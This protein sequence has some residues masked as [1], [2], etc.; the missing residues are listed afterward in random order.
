VC[1]LHKMCL[2][3][4]YYLTKTRIPSGL[5]YKSLVNQTIT[6]IP[7]HTHVTF[8]LS[9][10]SVYNN[11]SCFFCMNVKCRCNANL[12]IFSF[13]VF[14]CYCFYLCQRGYVF[15][16]VY[17]HTFIVCGSHKLDINRNT[18]K[19]SNKVSL[20]ACLFVC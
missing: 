3:N 4:S 12:L 13:T 20:C 8:P 16:S 5:N 9:N 6:Y 7:V 2:V 18:N 11:Y 14:I 10:L 1:I 19:Q 17:I 15:M